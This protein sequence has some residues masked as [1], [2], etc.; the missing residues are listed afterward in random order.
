MAEATAADL[1]ELR[2]DAPPA[3]AAARIA[4]RRAAGGDPSD[5]TVEVAA[6]LAARFAPWP[7]AIVVDATG[8]PGEALRRALDVT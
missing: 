4:A 5:V 8:G 2:V 3:V 7:E 6:E 1:V